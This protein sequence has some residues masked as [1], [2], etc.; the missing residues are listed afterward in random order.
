MENETCAARGPWTKRKIKHAKRMFE[1]SHTGAI[2]LCARSLFPET[3]D[4]IIAE[5]VRKFP[6]GK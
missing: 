1:K 3:G 4:T 2:R 5:E 6:G